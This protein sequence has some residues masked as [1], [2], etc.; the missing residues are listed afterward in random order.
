MA[1]RERDFLERI[2]RMLQPETGAETAGLIG[3]SMVPG[4][5]EAID[6]ADI[7]LG[8]RERSPSRVLTGLAGLAIPFATG[9]T[10]RVGAKTLSG[11]A[12]DMFKT[13]KRLNPKRA[14]EEL[15]EQ[16]E[17]IAARELE[18]VS[19]SEGIASL[20]RIMDKPPESYQGMRVE[21]V[22]EPASPE[23]LS[24]LATSAARQATRGAAS[25]NPVAN[26]VQN[27]YWQGTG[28]PEEIFN[29]LRTS[30]AFEDLSDLELRNQIVDGLDKI[31]ETQRV[32]G[33]VVPVEAAR[34]IPYTGADPAQLTIRD[35]PLYAR[36]PLTGYASPVRG[37]SAA[38]GLPGI[39][40]VKIAPEL[41]DIETGARA[42]PVPTRAEILNAPT[43]MHFDANEIIQRRAGLTDLDETP[44]MRLGDP[45]E[46]HM[47]TEGLVD[48]TQEFDLRTPREKL[49][50]L[51]NSPGGEALEAT[52]NSL[53]IN[54]IVDEMKLMDEYKDVPRRELFNA[55]ANVLPTMARNVAV[56][57]GRETLEKS[58]EGAARYA[59]GGIDLG[60]KGRASKARRRF[61]EQERKGDTARAARRE[62]VARE[63][64][65]R[66][67][68]ADPLPAYD[69]LFQYMG[70]GSMTPKRQFRLE[71]PNWREL[72]R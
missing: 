48:I 57:V 23:A 29:R 50:D 21:R 43:K 25:G 11:R 20:G 69:P 22:A 28:D 49:D 53:D 65:L 62:E 35:N 26:A 58:G 46:T 6:V 51:I 30:N 3:A 7:G 55:V 54:D 39:A 2:N 4:V 64:Y 36:G 17:Q 33:E 12:A 60:K 66:A 31:A 5:G 24:Q 70:A 47:P 63:A 41:R 32:L 61:F 27:I 68:E 1:S 8:L 9:T 14:S 37:Q 38:A 52:K 56:Q 19:S 13:L 40:Q 71:N 72:E 15:A 10:I 67:Y 16:A 18:R 45:T 59:L 34:K 44:R 42:K